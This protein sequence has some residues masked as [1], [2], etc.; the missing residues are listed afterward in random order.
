MRDDRWS[1][2]QTTLANRLS[3]DKTATPT[4]TSH[5]ATLGS[6]EGEAFYVS[7]IQSAALCFVS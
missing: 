2:G 1:F 7:T 6:A 5:V 4:A 3:I